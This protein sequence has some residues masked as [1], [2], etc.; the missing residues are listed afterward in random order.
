MDRITDE[1]MEFALNL[2]DK[3]DIKYADVKWL[4]RNSR[5]IAVKNGQVET[6]SSMKNQGIGIK[7]LVDGGYGFAATNNL[8]KEAIEKVAKR[9]YRVAKASGRTMKKPIELADEP[10]YEDTVI[11]P[12]KIDPSSVDLGEIVSMLIDATKAADIGDN[13]IKIRNSTYSHWKDHMV[14]WT[15]EGS[16]IDQTIA[17]TGGGVSTLAVEGRETQIRNYPSTVRGD[18]ATAGFEH[19]KEADIVKNA[20]IASQQALELLVA[21]QCPERN[22]ATIILKPAQLFLQ[23][24]ENM[25]GL[26]MD[27]AFDYE[28]AFAGTSFLK[29]HLVNNLMFGNELVTI[30]ADATFPK[31]LGTYF[32]DHEGVKAQNNNLLIDKGKLVGYM[33]SRETAPLMGLSRSSGAARASSYDRM[34]LIRMTNTILEPGDWNYEE[35]IEDTKDG[36]IFDTN[37]SW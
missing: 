25:H 17:V 24:H 8:S 22:D 30:K 21:K 3:P 27:R 37:V 28:A 31:G 29:P 7:L 18:L 1:L 15:S 32:Y 9:A 13:R 35:M 11:T 12:M 20:P 36:Y 19:F 34:P 14:L 2:T 6:N 23:I 5:E 33:S 16:R 26:E 4:Q 10:T